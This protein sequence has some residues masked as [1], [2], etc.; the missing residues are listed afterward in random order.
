[1]PATPPPA[2]GGASTNWSGDT[3]RGDGPGSEPESDAVREFISERAV[4]MMIT[5]CS[6]KG[7]WA[8][9]GFP[10]GKGATR[11]R[12][13]TSR[14][15]YAKY[16][17]DGAAYVDNSLK[18]TNDFMMSFQ[19]MVTEWFAKQPFSTGAIGVAGC[20]YLGGTTWH[21]AT[22]LAPACAASATSSQIQASTVWPK[23]W[24]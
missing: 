4:T 8:I 9:A 7:L 14:D 6:N 16:T 10:V 5:S 11:S 13:G 1:M 12:R 23:A 3:F 20:S 18:Q 22:T 17:E 24:R 21:S 2:D 15:R 19:H